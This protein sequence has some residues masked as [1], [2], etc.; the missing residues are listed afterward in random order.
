MCSG[1]R[2]PGDIKDATGNALLNSALTQPQRQALDKHAPTHL[3]VPSGRKHKLEYPELRRDSGP[4]GSE[5]VPS[6][7]LAVRLQE[8]FGL[9]E[10]PRIAGGRVPVLLHLLAPNYRPVQVTKDL[11]NFWNT[12]YAE[13]RKEL[14]GRYP[15][16]P[17]PEAPWEALPIAVGRPRRQG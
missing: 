16:H 7:I 9:A 1:C 3:T 10:S 15:K 5:A 17:W 12:T 2:T 4:A 11:R 8:L 14:R 13:V 6:P